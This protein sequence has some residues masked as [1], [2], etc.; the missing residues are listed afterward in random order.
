MG[1]LINFKEAEHDPS[2]L[3]KVTRDM[4]KEYAIC[5]DGRCSNPM[6][7]EKAM[8]GGGGNLDV[9]TAN[10]S[11]RVNPPDISDDKKRS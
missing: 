7:G 2:E 6:G 4:S 9:T 1:K 3:L 5:E 11:P 8:L 10:Q